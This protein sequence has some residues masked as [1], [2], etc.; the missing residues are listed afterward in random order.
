M[1]WDDFSACFAR[2]GLPGLA[3]E[4]YWCRCELYL[5]KLELVIF[6][7]VLVGGNVAGGDKTNES[8]GRNHFCTGGCFLWVRGGSG[9]GKRAT[10]CT[11]KLDTHTVI[12]CV[13]FI[14]CFVVLSKCV[15]PC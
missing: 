12:R 3:F 4:V 14:F 8:Y 2:S 10:T 5:G 11:S 9:A 7:A 15:L 6:F 13:A 1:S